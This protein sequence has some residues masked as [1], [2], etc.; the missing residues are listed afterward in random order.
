MTTKNE[1]I[2]QSG[3][4]MNVGAMAVGRGAVAKQTQSAQ[5]IQDLQAVRAEIDKL[6]ELLKAQASTLPGGQDVV[7][8]ARTVKEE[9]AKEKP[10]QLTIK[11]LLAGIADSVKSVASIATAV[12]AVR[13]AVIAFF[14]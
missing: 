10:N 13:A 9:L 4:T 6:L 1:G 2:I 8:S 7:H 3:G 14:G 12:E 5:P 11:S